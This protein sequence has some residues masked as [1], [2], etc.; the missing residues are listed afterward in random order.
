MKKILFGAIAT[1]ALS[2]TA[3]AADLP[4]RTYTK[5]PAPVVAPIYNWGGFYIGINGGAGSAHKCWDLIAVGVTPVIP[6][7]PEG[8]HNATGGTFG[9][10]VGY[11]W[12]ATNWVFGVEAQ[13]N[14]ANFKGSNVNP[15]GAAVPN[16]L[17]DVTKVD[18]FGLFT[19]QIGYAFNNILVYAKGG[20]AVVSDKYSNTFTPAALIV[21]NGRAVAGQTFAT[22]SETRWGG[23]AGAGVEFGFAPNWSVALE[24]DHLFM[25]RKNVT[26]YLVPPIGT[27]ISGTHGIGQ[28]V[29]IGTVRVNYTFGGPVVAKY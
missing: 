26:L 18:A 11:R 5:A 16:A 29:D 28:D 23:T 10:Q 27:G 8:C 19:G 25:G 2:S 15:F 14:W 17:N 12:Q 3:F 13:G 6:S 21:Q 7:L 1:I 20:A 24:Y 22:G 9:G 4:A